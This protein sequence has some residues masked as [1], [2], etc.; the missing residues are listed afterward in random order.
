MAQNDESRLRLSAMIRSNCG[1][2][3][4]AALDDPQVIEVMANPDGRIWLD[5]AGVGMVDTGAR[6]SPAA[7]GAILSTTASMLNTTITRDR[8]FLEG[9]FPLDGSRL[10]ALLPPI[11]GP[12]ASFALRKKATR[13]FT[14]DDYVA[15]GIMTSGQVDHFK[16][17]ITARENIL[18]VGGTGSGKTTLTNAGLRAIHDICPDDRLVA[19]EDTYE[20]Q[21]AVQNQVLAR[22]NENV[23][24]S[25][26]L[27]IAMRQRPDR[28]IVGEVRGAEAY[29]LLKAWNSG[30][31]GG[32]TTI[33]ANSASEGLDKLMHYIFESPD[34]GNFATETI[35]RMIAQTTNLVV[36]IER[37]SAPSG[38]LVKEMCRVRGHREG[39]FELAPL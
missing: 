39:S 2:V 33:H 6:L 25:M 31:P 10:S 36:F 13:V 28:I 9:E 18:I 15:A 24:M 19:L 29:T 34:A 21:V 38:R 30:H 7:V 35:G 26:L 17:A 27:R 32:L 20:L 1:P 37:T 22:S 8:P 16:R 12:N 11:V 14:L 23:T 4:L 3:I 5:R